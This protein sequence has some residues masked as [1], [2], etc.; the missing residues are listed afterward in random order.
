[1]RLED[2]TMNARLEYETEHQQFR[3]VA[4]DFVRDK[5][6][7]VHEDWEHASCLDRSLFT[8]AGKLG[9]LAFSVDEK[10]G[11][12]GADGCRDDGIR[13]GEVHRA[14]EA[15]AGI[16]FSLQND[17]VL[18]YLTEWTTDEQKARWLPGVVSGET[19]LGIA[20]TEPGTGS[21]LTG[22][23]TSAVR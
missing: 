18:P 4:R 15:A 10:Y 8:E 9:L 7:P 22:I 16:A 23:R 17:V 1:H 2:H 11:G 5:I 19:V 12:P 14:R 3:E 13:S 21:D 6:T 20:M